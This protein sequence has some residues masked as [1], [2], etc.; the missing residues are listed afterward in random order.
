MAKVMTELVEECP[1]RTFYTEK[2]AKTGVIKVRSMLADIMRLE[3][4]LRSEILA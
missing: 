1:K 3:Q 4:I 2:D